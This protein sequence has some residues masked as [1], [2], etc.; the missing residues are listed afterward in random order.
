MNIIR[1]RY[2][3]K[4]ELPVIYSNI[5]FGKYSSIDRRV[6][7]S[8]SILK[9]L[10]YYER[11]PVTTIHMKVFKVV[12]QPQIVWR[13]IFYFK[14]CLYLNHIEN[15]ENTHHTKLSYPLYLNKYIYIR[16]NLIDKYVSE[17]L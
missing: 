1:Q 7:L 2:K 3:H 5:I 10:D 9:K 13:T 11:I 6:F 16:I 8:K 17:Y 12:D 15:I 14:V 4:K